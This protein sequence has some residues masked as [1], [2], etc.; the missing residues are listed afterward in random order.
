MLSH[1]LPI[2]GLWVFNTV[3]LICFAFFVI[4]VL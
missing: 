4:A 3:V 1:D 2:F